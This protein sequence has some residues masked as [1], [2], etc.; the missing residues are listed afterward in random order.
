M[1]FDVGA[2]RSRCSRPWM[3][4]NPPPKSLSEATTER[5]R[6]GSR[7]AGQASGVEHAEPYRLIRLR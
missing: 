7:L 5:L 1:R 6:M 2:L 3:A 4:T